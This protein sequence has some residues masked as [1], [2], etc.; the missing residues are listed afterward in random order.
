M[1]VTGASGFIGRYLVASLESQGHAVRRL[2]RSSPQGPA[3]R[4]TDYSR[5]S[6]TR[7]LE[8][9]DA[10]VHLAGRRMTRE[11]APMD[12][13]P[14]WHPNVAVIGDL[15]AAARDTGVKRLVLS[16]TIAVYSPQCGL[17]YRE[18]MPGRPVNAYGLSKLMAEEY[19]EMLTRN[20]GPAAFRLRLAAVY[21]AGEKGTPA[22][23]RFV[24]QA[25][26]GQTLILTGNADFRIDQ[27]YV[28]DA[29]AAML[30]ALRAPAEA[31]G[32]YNIGGAHAWSV[33]QIAE[34]ANAVFGNVG[35][36]DDRTDSDAP[37]AHAIMDISAASAALGWRPV[38]NLCH[39]M[40]DF[41]RTLLALDR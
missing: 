3:D 8:G 38:H 36:L 23:M 18:D 13:A 28:R 4:Q 27:L 32:A 40:E 34:T 1:A 41:R 26:R 6:L 2:G 17:P 25:R 11:D 10:L 35:N 14:F 39:G 24:E 20:G 21:G 15:V 9:V 33:R 5:E 19:L 7:V 29:V 16:S 12:V 30:A 31:A 37:M 22:L